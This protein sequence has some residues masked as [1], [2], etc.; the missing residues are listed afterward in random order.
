MLELK[1]V[2]LTLE[3]NQNVKKSVLHNINMKFW[4]GKLY[5]KQKDR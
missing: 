5:E 1:N 2:Y 4:P 3:N